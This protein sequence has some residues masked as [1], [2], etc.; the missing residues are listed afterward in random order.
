MRF[1]EKLWSYLRRA[2]RRV[3]AS[4]VKHTLQENEARL[5]GVVLRYAA[6]FGGLWTSRKTPCCLG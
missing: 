6:C 3:E 1:G 5:V 2:Q 4:V